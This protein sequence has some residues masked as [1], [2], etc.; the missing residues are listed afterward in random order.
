MDR[1][2]ELR[3]LE[4]SKNGPLENWLDCITLT[5]Q[6]QKSTSDDEE[7]SVPISPKPISGWIVPLQVGFKSIAKLNPPGTVDFSRDR[8]TPLCFVEPIYSLGEWV[9]LHRIQD[10]ESIFWKSC[11]KPHY[12]YCKQ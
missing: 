8:S 6:S 1:S 12:Y 9:G 3:K 5:Y 11:T 7:N 4:K 2:D 10:L